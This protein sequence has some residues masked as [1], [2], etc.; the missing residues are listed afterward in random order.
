MRHSG[1]RLGSDGPSTSPMSPLVDAASS[2]KVD[3]SEWTDTGME[4]H[5]AHSGPGLPASPSPRPSSSSP[6]SE[7]PGH[8]AARGH[9]PSSATA[10][11]LPCSHRAGEELGDLQ[12]LCLYTSEHRVKNSNTGLIWPNLVILRV[13]I[14]TILGPG[15]RDTTLSIPRDVRSLTTFSD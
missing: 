3:A 15:T 13:S 7:Q 12:S 14:L 10:L 5:A 4:A 2:S 6:H 8:R 9:R 11:L 1:Q